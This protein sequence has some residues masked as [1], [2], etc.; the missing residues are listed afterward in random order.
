MISF[1]FIKK[2]SEINWSRYGKWTTPLLMDTMISEALAKPYLSEIGLN[3]KLK[4]HLIVDGEYYWD[5]A[6][7]KNIQNIF[8]NAIKKNPVNFFTRFYKFSNQIT[9]E[10]LTKIKKLTKIRLAELNNAELIEIFDKWTNLVMP[11]MNLNTSLMVLD[12]V[13]EPIVREKIGKMSG[14]R[15]GGLLIVELMPPKKIANVIKEEDHLLEIAGEINK[16]KELKNAFRINN[17]KEI[18]FLLKRNY[19]R[20]YQ[21][22]LIHCEK[23]CWL[24]AI[25]WWGKPFDIEYYVQRLKKYLKFDPGKALK[26]KRQARLKKEKNI[27]KKLKELKS[28][29]EFSKLISVLRDLIDLKQEQWDAVS[30][31]NYLARP[32]FKETGERINLCHEEILQSSVHE[33][34][35]LLRRKKAINRS[36]YK[37]R[38]KHRMV[39]HYN[40]IK[41]IIDGENVVKIKKHLFKIE[42]ILQKNELSG[43]VSYPGIVRGKVSLISTIESIHKMHEGEILVCPMTNPDYMP[44]VHKA[45]AIITDEGGILCHAAIISR[46]LKIPCII[47]TKIA[48]KVLHDGD[49]VE[50]DADKG[51]VRLIK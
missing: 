1:T 51:V 7:Y 30:I 12:D 20:I 34:I 50:V 9:N 48:T 47:G 43:Q 2:I 29:R 22:V 42:K 18:E 15:E 46:E 27:T 25:D 41:K 3:I 8:Y 40:K 10:N 38:I 28:D 26:E 21:K 23:Y 45:K 14:K 5:D 39:I 36:L 13:A 19:S 17:S 33:I 4:R 44:A 11:L 37:N 6:E 32:L 31:S 35:G 24:S 49:L 16:N